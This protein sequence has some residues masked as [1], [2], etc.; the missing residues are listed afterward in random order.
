M[1]IAPEYAFGCVKGRRR[2][3][4]ISVQ[5]I[6]MERLRRAR[7]GYATLFF[8]VKNAFP[9][10]GHIAL[11][12]FFSHCKD[13]DC[14]LFEVFLENHISVVECLDGALVLALKRGVPPGASTATQLFNRGYWKATEKYVGQVGSATRLLLTSS[15]VT[16]QPINTASTCFVDDLATCVPLPG[17]RGAKAKIQQC[18][19]A[20]DEALRDIGVVQNSDK[21]EALLLFLGQGSRQ[22]MRQL[23]WES[24]ALFKQQARYL[25]PHLQWRGL[26]SPEVTRRVSAARSAW[27]AYRRFWFARC[28][29]DFKILVFRAVVAS[30][31]CSG[32]VALVL[33]DAHYHRLDVAL[34]AYLRKLL[35]GKA[36]AKEGEASQG[37]RYKALS[38]ARVTQLSMVCSSRVE[39]CVQRLGMLQSCFRQPQ[40][41]QLYLTALLGS[42][43]FENVAGGHAWSFAFPA[44]C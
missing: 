19:S 41:H 30:T 22:A 25:G 42:Y 10:L 40:Q 33:S 20:L 27:W 7:I 43:E 1:G 9:S 12:G 21:R 37:V 28:D 5:L 44:S 4:A 29:F 3:E 18:T 36:C 6:N 26:V 2:E 39:L 31:L 14:Q 17:F 38:N 13:G 32:L 15:V 23:T 24:Q 16:Q 8:D 35:A 11:E 34:F